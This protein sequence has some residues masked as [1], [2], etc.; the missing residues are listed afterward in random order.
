MTRVAGRNQS[1]FA[2]PPSADEVATRAYLRHGNRTS[3][4]EH[5]ITHWFEAE[6]QLLAERVNLR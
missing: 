5:V 1:G 3:L 4:P 2:M 6:S